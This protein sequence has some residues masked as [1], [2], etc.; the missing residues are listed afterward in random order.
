MKTSTE[1]QVKRFEVG[2]TISLVGYMSEGY[3]GQSFICGGNDYLLKTILE[4]ARNNTYTTKGVAFYPK[5]RVL[6]YKYFV[7][8]KNCFEI[9]VQWVDPFND[10]KLLPGV[11][12]YTM[13]EYEFR[14]F[15]ESKKAEIFPVG[16]W[17]YYMGAEAGGVD[18]G[19][20]TT[21]YWHKGIVGQIT[22]VTDSG[23]YE[24]AKIGNMKRGTPGNKMCAFRRATFE[25]IA[26]VSFD[27]IV[28][29]GSMPGFAKATT[30]VSKYVLDYGSSV[31]ESVLK[32]LTTDETKVSFQSK[33]LVA[34][35][36]N[37]SKDIDNFLL[38][39]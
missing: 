13:L 2:Q 11:P 15:T 14:E 10:K 35:K 8:E 36:I 9:I 12:A 27:K 4:H 30:D 5:A 3:A 32:S 33:Q 1:A 29:E 28:L 17:V 39:N 19:G 26:A 20:D 21:D 34:N 31:H 37:N 38:I 6:N 23:F 22:N 7:L 25:E 16:T 18:T 24:F